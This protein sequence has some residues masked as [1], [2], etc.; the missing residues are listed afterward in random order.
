MCPIQKQ[1]PIAPMPQKPPALPKCIGR[2]EKQIIQAG[3]D[4]VVAAQRSQ[5][6]NQYHHAADELLLR[7]CPERENAGRGNQ[8]SQHQKQNAGPQHGIVAGKLQGTEFPIVQPSRHSYSGQNAEPTTNYGQEASPGLSGP[9]DPKPVKYPTHQHSACQYDPYAYYPIQ[10]FH[11]ASH[12]AHDH[13][14][15]LIIHRL[16]RHCKKPLNPAYIIPHSI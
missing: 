7:P 16:V 1:P 4:T 2:C 11:I 10:I 6:N 5:K 12:H 8:Q 3:I 9:A 13:C 15:W 14:G